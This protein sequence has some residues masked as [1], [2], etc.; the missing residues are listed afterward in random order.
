MDKRTK[1]IRMEK[2]DLIV[3]EHSGHIQPK[4]ANRDSAY[5]SINASVWTSMSESNKREVMNSKL[6]QEISY[7]SV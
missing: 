3:A 1:S 5:K 6:P 4:K 2:L 7:P